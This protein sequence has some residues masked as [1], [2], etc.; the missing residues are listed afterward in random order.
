[1]FEVAQEWLIARGLE[2]SWADIV[3]R[4]GTGLLILFVAWIAWAIVRPIVRK[5]IVRLAASSATKWDDIILEQG[6]LDHLLRLVSEGRYRPSVGRV[7]AFDE[8]P[9]ALRDFRERRVL[10]RTVVKIPVAS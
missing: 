5:V 10:G 1:M 7:V 3:V 4:S 8:V 2:A 9:E 6:V